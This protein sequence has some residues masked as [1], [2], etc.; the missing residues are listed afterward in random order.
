MRKRRG[1]GMGGEDE[2]VGLLAR[3]LEEFRSEIGM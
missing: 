1:G 3:K 2:R